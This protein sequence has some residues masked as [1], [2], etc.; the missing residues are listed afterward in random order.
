[1]MDK[2]SKNNLSMSPQ[3][4]HF[5]SGSI[6]NL[7]NSGKS[8]NKTQKRL[9]NFSIPSI[10]SRFLTPIL[11]FDAQD[12]DEKSLLDVGYNIYDGSIESVLVSKVA[13]LTNDGSN[14]GPGAYNVDVS[15][16]AIAN[17]PRGAI[18]W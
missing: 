15:S 9:H 14:L 10:P 17:S 13:R 12:K 3:Q 18:A 8:L 6:S 16:K 7:Q 11:K 1:M 4:L 2:T 5:G